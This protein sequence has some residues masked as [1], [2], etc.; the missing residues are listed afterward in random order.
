MEKLN[1]ILTIR[2]SMEILHKI[3]EAVVLVRKEYPLME[4]VKSRIIRAS[5]MQRLLGRNSG[6]QENSGHRNFG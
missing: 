5:I 4:G 1:D 3:D 2:L 6:H